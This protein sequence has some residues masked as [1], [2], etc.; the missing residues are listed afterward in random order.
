MALVSWVLLYFP[1]TDC[2]HHAGI[3]VAVL[4]AGATIAQIAHREIP[5]V[6]VDAAACALFT[7]SARNLPESFS[8]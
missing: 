6:S 4:S 2:L 7:A 8:L 5:G 1:V 3:V